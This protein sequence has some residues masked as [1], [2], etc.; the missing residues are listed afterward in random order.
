M[1]GGGG[2]GV[3][4]PLVL[5]YG[6]IALRQ[7]DVDL[8]AVDSR[9]WLNDAVISFAFEYLNNQHPSVECL[10]VSCTNMLAMIPRS[11]T[12]M[13]EGLSVAIRDVLTV[14]RS[15]KDQKQKLELVVAAVNNSMEPMLAE[16][17]SHWSLLVYEASSQTFFHFD[18][19]PGSNERHARDLAKRLGDGA[20][21]QKKN[22]K[23]REAK[24]PMQRNGHACGLYAISIARHLCEQYSSNSTLDRLG[25]EDCIKGINDKICPKRVESLRGELLSLIRSMQCKEEEEGPKPAGKD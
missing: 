9:E 24:T 14:G 20:L 6:D 19:L 3:V 8:L 25:M 5:S 21:G 13:Q 2:G 16:S 1:G 17:G 18:S 10:H 11:S 22:W 7:S 4:D 12:E 23:F 15:E